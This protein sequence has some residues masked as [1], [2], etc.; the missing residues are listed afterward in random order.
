MI[1]LE[2]GSEVE[3]T[4]IRPAGSPPPDPKKGTDSQE[5]IKKEER[6]L[7]E[8]VRDR[9]ERRE[10]EEARKKRENPRKPLI[11][12]ARQRVAWMQ[13]TPDE[14]FVL[15]G[16]TTAPEDAKQTIIPSFVTESAYTE[17][18]SGRT[19][20]GRCAR[21]SSC[22]HHRCRNG[23]RSLDRQAHAGARLV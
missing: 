10:Q 5:W 4:D 19:K 8:S 14:K 7:L 20:V 18:I 16:F 9:A 17:D 11:L 1:S 3:L 2:D 21:R 23:R 22:R 6:D 13:L 12:A 15:A